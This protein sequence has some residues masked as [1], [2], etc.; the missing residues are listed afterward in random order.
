MKFVEVVAA[1]GLSDP[2]PYADGNFRVEQAGF[3][4]VIVNILSKD[5]NTFY[6]KLNGRHLSRTYSHYLDSHGDDGK[7]TAS[8][9][10]L[11]KAAVR[12]VI[13]IE[14][15]GGDLEPGSCLTVLKL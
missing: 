14:G 10:V 9:S 7:S 12:D 6:I 15:S 8:T 5:M 1:Y 13:S 2:P 4:L 11:I 3:Y